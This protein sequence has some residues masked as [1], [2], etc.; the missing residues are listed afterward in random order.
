[1]TARAELARLLKE[2]TAALKALVALD[3]RIAQLREEVG[4]PPPLKRAPPR[5]KW[6]RGET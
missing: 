3:A 6:R 1:M 5:S 4:P 2:R